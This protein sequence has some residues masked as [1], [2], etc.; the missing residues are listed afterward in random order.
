MLLAPPA[1]ILANVVGSH[2]QY[3]WLTWCFS[4][5]KVSIAVRQ[6]LLHASRTA[7]YPQ[8]S[9]V[10]RRQ[11]STALRDDTEIARGH[12]ELKAYL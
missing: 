3:Q 10:R 7:E 5:S 8:D 6:S 4:R 9:T 12:S 1:A 11:P 2:L